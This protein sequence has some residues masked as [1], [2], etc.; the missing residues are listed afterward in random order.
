S[1]ESRD[2]HRSRLFAV[3]GRRL[4]GV[5]L[6]RSAPFSPIMMAAALVLPLMILGITEAS[7]I[8]RLSASAGQT[9]V[10]AGDPRQGFRPLRTVRAGYLH[11]QRG[12]GPRQV[13]VSREA[14]SLRRESQA[15]SRR[16]AG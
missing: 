6:M 14:I 9:V 16:S 4:V 12:R 13:A 10:T 15:A 3:A 5:V 11:H 7:T 2:L 1:L 8:R